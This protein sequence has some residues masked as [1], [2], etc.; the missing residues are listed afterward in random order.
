MGVAGRRDIKVEISHGLSHRPW[1]PQA[2]ASLRELAALEHN[3]NGYGERAVTDEALLCAVAV[4]EAVGAG[5]C[6]DIVPVFDGGVQIEWADTEIEVPPARA[7]V[8]VFLPGIDGDAVLV[9]DPY[10]GEAHSSDWA[11][12]RDAIAAA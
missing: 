5:P 6:P 9:A 10:N 2:L 3:W 1:W 7:P 4:L 8:E 11:R 12:V